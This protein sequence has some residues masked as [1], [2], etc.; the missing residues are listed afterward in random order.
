MIRMILIFL[1][2][3]VSVWLGIQLSYDPGYVLISINHWTVETTLWV[4]L[5]SLVLAFAVI[6]LLLRLI[7][8]LGGGPLRVRHWIKKRHIR[9]AQRRTRQGFIEFSE[10]YWSKAQKNLIK[11][12]PD[13]ETPLLNYLTAARA[14]QKMGDSKLRDHYLREAQQSMPEAKIAVELTQA[15][16][17][18]ANEQWEQ[19]L[20]T[21]RH[22]QDLAPHHPYVMKLLIRLYEEVRDWPQLIHIL[23][24][25]KRQQIINEKEYNTLL[26][27][28][29]INHLNDLIQQQQHTQISKFL[30]EL[31]RN[32]RSDSEFVAHHSRYLWNNDRKDETEYLLRRSLQ[33]EYDT[34]LID[35]YGQLYCN[36]KQLSFAESLLKK[37][38]HCAH[39]L[40]CCARLCKAQQ[41]WG[42]ARQYLED[43]IQQ[44]P[45]RDAYFT[46]GL[47]LEGL[48]ETSEAMAAYKAGLELET[49]DK[50]A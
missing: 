4:A 44:Q 38:P 43:S 27:K 1:L 23:P 48:Q 20:A 24:Q 12:L 25:A 18:L 33:K 35:L 11:A 7:H 9:K 28:A 10:G 31:P 3:L 6:Y 17:Q 50:N 19:A 5:M 30:E 21:L 8:K 36:D 22:L 39:L 15:Q 13:A 26:H 14:A 2:L 29:S 34:Q 16:L 40:L 46:L 37:Q 42:K 49:V 41:L 47:L 32:I 45:T